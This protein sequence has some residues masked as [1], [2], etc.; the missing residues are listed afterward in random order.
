MQSRIKIIVIIIVTIFASLLSG[1]AKKEANVM[2]GDVVYDI[3]NIQKNKIVHEDEIYKNIIRSFTD[4]SN[5]LP[6]MGISKNTLSV[7]DEKYFKSNDLLIIAFSTNSEYKYTIENM[8]LLGN[9]LT[10]K[11]NENIPRSNTDLFIYRVA[12]VNI[13]KGNLPDDT[14]IDAEINKVIEK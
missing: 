6:D 12:L 8:I 5:V 14:Q 2:F 11:I 13:P 4:A 3:L 7:Y 10:V 1:C 9:S